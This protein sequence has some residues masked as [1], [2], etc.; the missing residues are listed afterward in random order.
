L[1]RFRS[2]EIA[3]STSVL[4]LLAICR[5][6]IMSNRSNAISMASVIAV[7]ITLQQVSSLVIQERRIEKESVTVA[8]S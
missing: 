8:E 1:A 5:G 4:A 2:F 7:S 6:I 3:S